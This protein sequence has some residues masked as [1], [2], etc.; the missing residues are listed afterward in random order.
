MN[1]IYFTNKGHT[2][3]LNIPN[4]WPTREANRAQAEFFQ[5]KK[6]ILLIDPVLVDRAYYTATFQVYD[7]ERITYYDLRDGTKL[8][9]SYG[10]MWAELKKGDIHITTK[11]TAATGFLEMSPLERDRFWAYR[12]EALQLLK[13]GVEEFDRYF[14]EQKYRK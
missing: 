8:M 6:L 10:F 3:K 4:I 11:N 13:I 7:A 12:D 9:S 14:P 1:E 5:G 2:N